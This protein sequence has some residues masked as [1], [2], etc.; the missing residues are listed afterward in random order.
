MIRTGRLSGLRIGAAAVS[1]HIAASAVF[2]Q[3]PAIGSVAMQ[4]ATVAGALEVTGTRAVLVGSSTVTARDH[5]AEITLVRGGTVEVC[6]TSGLKLSSGATGSA[7]APLMLALDRGAIEV[8][9]TAAANDIILTPDLRFA[10][11]T[12][13]PLDLR[14]RVARNGDT[15][16]EQ[17]AANAPILSITDSFGEA[18]YEVHAG[19]HLLFEHG[20]LREVVDHESSPCG[21]PPAPRTMSLA[22]AALAAP[23]NNAENAH[24]FPAAESTGL[25]PTPEI[26]QAQPGAVHT[27]V[28]TTLTYEA[29]AI[30]PVAPPPAVTQ[31]AAVPQPAPVPQHSRGF[32]HAIG[33]FFTR[34]FG[35]G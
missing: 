8:R 29:P 32:A 24:P 34:L 2:A 26:P 33:H 3:Q 21:C 20:N 23:G 16:V 17:R 31:P 18:T 7:G 10:V 27:E 5:A 35:G 12:A 14:L 9:M 6:Q 28:A 19:Q 11:R 22:E 4:D 15:C 25:A 1:L 13:G 30:S